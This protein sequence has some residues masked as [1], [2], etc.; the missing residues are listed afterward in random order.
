VLANLYHPKTVEA[1]LEHDGQG[2]VP[3]LKTSE[4]QFETRGHRRRLLEIT[5]QELS[6]FARL[7]DRPGTPAV[8][9]R[10][11]ILHSDQEL[12]VL[13]KLAEHPRRLRDLSNNTFATMMWNE[14][15]AQQDGTIRREIR[16]PANTGEWILSGPHFYIGNPF[17]KSPREQC[18]HNKDYD[19]VDLELASD[20]YLPRTIYVPACTPK[21]Y[22]A[23]A[24]RFDSRPM[25]DFYRHVHRNMLPLTGERTLTAAIIPP[26]AGHIDGVVSVAC[27]DI[28][29][30]LLL[31]GACSALPTD[32]F[33]RA[34]G[35]AH[36]QPGSAQLLPLGRRDSKFGDSL[37]ARVLRLN[38]VATHY[39]SLWN[40]VWSELVGI[41]WTLA[42]PR[43]SRWLV[44]SKKWQ[45][46]SALR[47]HFERR[48]ALVEIDALTALELNL[49]IDELCTIYRIQFPVLRGYEKNTWYD[50]KG[51]I[52]FTNN[53]GLSGVGLDRKDFEL[54]QSALKSGEKL[55][56]DFGT[57]GLEPPFDVRD[58]EDDMRTAYAYFA[59][60]LGKP[61]S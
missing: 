7:F 13:R 59:E 14:T 47:N 57:Q 50:R 25:T 42:D 36:L 24:P 35:R 43:L 26:G 30:L 55:P 54:W 41:E 44:A 38:C 17:N 16:F 29:D 53:R 31:S 4:D 33:V 58:R 27:S 46:S 11:P 10:M 40:E 51:H 28:Y 22:E 32:F 52:A 23:R 34:L 48:W 39:S 45:R 37:V 6:L 18:R 9:G 61:A 56:K 60:K 2:E 5:E 49:T 19:E 21:E 1:S 3:G 15:T 8:E 20:D 12:S